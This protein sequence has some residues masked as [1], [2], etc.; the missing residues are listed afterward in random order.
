MSLLNQMMKYWRL[1]WGL[2]GFLKEPITLEQSQQ[3]ISQRL[4]NRERNLLAIVKSA[5][6]ENEYSP[7]LKLLKIAGCEYGDFEKM[8]GAKGIDDTLKELS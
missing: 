3:I 5:I 7:Y 6:Y 2:R 1:T 4:E 8:L